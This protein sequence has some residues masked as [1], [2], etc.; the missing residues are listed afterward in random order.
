MRNKLLVIGVVSWL[1]V[2]LHITPSSAGVYSDDL[3]KCFVNSTTTSDR[4][5]LVRWMF[6][7]AASHPAVSSIVMVSEVQRR[8]SDKY[9]AKLSERLLFET[10]KKETEQAVKYEGQLALQT[11][12][13]VLGQVAGRELFSDPTVSK[14][15]ANL[16]SYID[17]GKLEC[18]FGSSPQAR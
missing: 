9:M 17:K 2:D 14:A 16:N 8:D 5:G 12:F 10:C 3:A 13:Q 1:G 15:M 7:A 6:T 4:N 18:R 11:G